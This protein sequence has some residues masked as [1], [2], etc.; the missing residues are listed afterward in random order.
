M[1]ASALFASPFSNWQVSNWQEQHSNPIYNPYPGSSLYDDFFP[2][3]LFDENKFNGDGDESYYKMW[4][5]GSGISTGTLALSTSH[6]G[7]HWTLKGDTNLV[8]PAGLDVGHP[9]VLYDPNGFGGSAYHYQM[10][11]WNGTISSISA[12]QYTQSTDGFVW[13]TP[14]PISQD[15]FFP[16]VDNTTGSYFYQ[17]YGP[18]FV[19]YNSQATS[20]PGQP[21]TYPYV[22][23][24]DSAGAGY[25]SGNDEQEAIA[26]AYSNDGISWTR[27]GTQPVLIP[28][29]NPDDWDGLYSFRPSIIQSD[30]VYYMFYSGSDGDSSTGTPF[31]HG[32]GVASSTDGINWT[33]DTANPIFIN[34]DGVAWRNDR[35]YTPVVLFGTFKGNRMK[36]KMWFVGGNIPYTAGQAI[37]YATLRTS[38]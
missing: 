25:V 8:A 29:G 15:P 38:P 9:C 3:V 26:L 31:A 19:I 30:G 1:V 13:T 23:F 27:Y 20:T 4:H 24:F 36:G 21:Y 12:I 35:S 17:L 6:D 10:W 5:Q 33:K 7:I 32:L 28:S 14:Q 37:G 34:T 11:F 18:G 2:C 22:M 16:L